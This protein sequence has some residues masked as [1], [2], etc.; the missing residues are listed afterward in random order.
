VDGYLGYL[1]QRDPASAQQVQQSWN[2]LKAVGAQSALVTGFSQGGQHCEPGLAR[3]VGPSAT[4]WVA[5]YRDADAAKAGY[6]RG[7]LSFPTPTQEREQPGLHV[8][9]ATGLGIDAW[10]L[11]QTQPP[12]QIYLAWWR[13]GS[14]TVFLVTVGVD[15]DPSRSLAVK[16]DNRMTQSTD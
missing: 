12:P 10:T 3:G 1:R 5:S 9:V 7:V 14:L 2:A 11:S 8:G 4:A 15:A 16:V 13:E 6:R